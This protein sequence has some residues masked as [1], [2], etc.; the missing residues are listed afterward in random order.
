MQKAM[1]PITGKAAAQKVLTILLAALM[2]FL[3]GCGT[4]E[5]GT[6]S[7]Q[8]ES[9]SQAESGAESS[10]ESTAESVQE[11]SGEVSP[12]SRPEESAS[13]GTDP[14]GVDQLKAALEKDVEALISSL[15]SE[16][17][18]L[19][20]DIDTYEKY[21]S[22]AG[23][24]ESFYASTVETVRQF[25]IKLRE[26][27]VTYATVITASDG[28]YSEKYDELDAIYD[29]I[30]DDVGEEIYDEIYDGVLDDMYD[31]FYDGILDK[32]Y[33]SAP[34]EEWSDA[35]SDEY[36]WWS[37]ARSDVYDEW[38][39]FRSDVYDFF[40]DVRSAVFK[41]DDEKTVSKIEDFIADIEKLK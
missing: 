6:P 37:D 4:A 3:A 28:S 27:S 7:S 30:Y 36:D 32:A 34:Y 26:Y 29:D 38:S 39:D 23:R 25:C 9:S 22:N 31:T 1:R 11:S 24:V 18:E 20:A 40:S 41:D 8:T 5:S 16:Y 10:E 13:A 21:I 35:R 14:Q 12:A 2:L 15:T 33:D 19:A 17:E